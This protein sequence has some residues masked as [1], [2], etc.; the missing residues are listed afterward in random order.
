MAAFNFPDPTV[1]QT[2]VNPITGSTY[3]WKE[4]PGKWVLTVSVRDVSDIIWEGDNPPIPIGDYKLW[5]STDTLELYFYY[6]DANGV[7][8][9]VPT[10]VP[11]QVLEDLNAFAAQ[12]KIDIDQLQYKQQI[13]QN[14]VD[15]IY[16][17]S[18]TGAGNRPPVFSDTEPTV[19]PDFTAPDNNLLAGDVWFDTTDLEQLIQYIYDGTQWLLA[20]NYVNS[21]A[22]QDNPKGKRVATV[23]TSRSMMSGMRQAI[24]GAT[25]FEDLKSRLLAKLEEME[26]SSEFSEDPTTFDIPDS[27]Y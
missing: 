19:H 13:L 24:L 6:C 11:I 1:Q 26:N 16:L 8:A 2:V 18:Q 22:E 7:C 4:P 15:Q 9:W 21:L 5:Y 25:D 14:A 20:G 17:D 23:S 10:S 27:N 3:Q 12:A